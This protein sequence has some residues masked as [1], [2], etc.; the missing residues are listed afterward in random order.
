M[1]LVITGTAPYSFIRLLNEMDMISEELGEE[2]VMQIGLAEYTPKNIKRY[3]AFISEESIYKLYNNASLI[4][5]H[6]GIGTIMNCMKLNKRFIIVPRLA[7][8]NEHLDD[9]QLYTA[10]EFETYGVPVVYD[11]V[12]LK[13]TIL[14]YVGHVTL[15]VNNANLIHE[16]S[17]FLTTIEQCIDK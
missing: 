14:G 3:F 5:C 9:H 4:I 1:I 15:N 10:K 16:L 7:K 8:Y 2:V 11:L 17:I 12:D 6:A 13:Q